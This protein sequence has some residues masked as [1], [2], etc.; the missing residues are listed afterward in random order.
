VTAHRTKVDWAR[1]NQVLVDVLYAAA[2]RI[3][4]VSDNLYTSTPASLD[5]TFPPG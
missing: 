5:E 3:R 2:E 4:L 1:Q